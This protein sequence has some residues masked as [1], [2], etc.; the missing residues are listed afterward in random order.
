MSF[1]FA[2]I[3]LPLAVRGRFTYRIPEEI[4]EE[5]KPG[6]RV[7]VQFGGR[8]LNTGIV[9]KLHNN[10][11]EFK[12]IK[13]IISVSDKIPVINEHQLKLWLWISEYYLCTEGEV[14]KAALPNEISLNT[15]Q[16]RLETY[17]KLSKQYSED[18]LNEI[19]DKLSKAPKQQEILSTYI[20]LTGYATGKKITL[21]SKS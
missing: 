3:I 17:I 15:F 10:Q 13:P 6:V 19:L 9:C 1:Q 8:K 16:P 20:R 14:M 4:S 2:D 18:E 7:T 5:V 11:P 21:L 12:N